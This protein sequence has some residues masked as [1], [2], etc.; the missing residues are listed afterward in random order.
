V[1]RVDGADEERMSNLRRGISIQRREGGRL[2]R[3]SGNLW[4]EEGE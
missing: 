4:N 1:E 3:R 2:R